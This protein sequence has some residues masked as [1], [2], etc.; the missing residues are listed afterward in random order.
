MEPM[1]P[2]QSNT[3][4]EQTLNKADVRG[5]LL[6]RLVEEGWTPASDPPNTDRIVQ[7]AGEDGSTGPSAL[8]FY[9]LKAVMPKGRKYWWTHPKMEILPDHAVLA[10]REQRTPSGV[11]SRL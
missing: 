6:S 4:T 3:Q 8:C 1:K 7:V 9:D 10:W 2:E 11:A 5:M